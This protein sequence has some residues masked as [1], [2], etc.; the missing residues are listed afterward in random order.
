[1][2]KINKYSKM[3]RDSLGQETSLDF[4]KELNG[5][6][7]SCTLNEK[8]EIV[9]KEKWIEIIL[10]WILKDGRIKTVD[11]IGRELMGILNS[12]VSQSNL[13]KGYVIRNLLQEIQKISKNL[14][15]FQDFQ[16]QLEFLEFLY[17]YFKR[18]F[19]HRISPRRNRNE[20][21]L[22]MGLPKKFENVDIKTLEKVRDF[23]SN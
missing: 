12:L 18:I 5:F 16:V 17:R 2:R 20:F 14:K 11:V 7:V 21:T 8:E 1:M 13:N 23:C 3:L 9:F 22:K 6:L 15:R 10:E 4:L 19:N